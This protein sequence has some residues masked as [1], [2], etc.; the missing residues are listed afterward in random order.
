M[1]SISN[2]SMESNTSKN[3]YP[4]LSNPAVLIHSSLPARGGHAKTREEALKMLGEM[5]VERED[6]KE[7]KFRS[8]INNIHR[9]DTGLAILAEK[10]I[11]RKEKLKV[12]RAM[13]AKREAELREAELREKDLGSNDELKIA[14]NDWVEADGM[15]DWEVLEN[16]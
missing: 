14:D 8:S 4:V 16:A 12:I 13:N 5:L 6:A 1:N 2:K 15:E 3:P 7:G 9:A 10:N 11:H